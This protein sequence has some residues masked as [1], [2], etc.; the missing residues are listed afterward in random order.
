MRSITRF[1][2]LLLALLT[3]AFAAHAFLLHKNGLPIYANR[4]LWAYVINYLLAV[5]IYAVLY[6]L[7]KR[8]TPQL[9][10]IYMGGSFLKFIVF[11]IVFYPF[12]KLD[13]EVSTLEF[14]AF[15]TPYVLCLI[16]ET[17]GVI[18]FLKN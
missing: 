1:S 13:G 8:M 11:F 12:Y 17:S 2:L 18:D 15:F 6:L 5:F 9:G 16:A 4:I 7:R 10:F 14:A 3:L